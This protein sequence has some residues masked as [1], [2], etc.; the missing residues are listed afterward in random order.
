MRKPRKLATMFFVPII[1][2]ALGLF[3]FAERPGFVGFRNVDLVLLFG[4]GMCFGI[5]LAE[6]A[7]HVDVRNLAFLVPMLMGAVGL[8]EFTQR[9]RFAAFRSSDIV[10]LFGCG[11]CFGVAV[12]ALVA[13]L[14]RTRGTA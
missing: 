10:L 7:I 12:A 1:I 4:C 14:R 13:Y 9:P 6:Y 8:F 3:Q 5:A 2:G 11:M